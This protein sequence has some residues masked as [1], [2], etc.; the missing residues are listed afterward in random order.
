M[1]M[2]QKIGAVL[3]LSA[4]ALSV[5]LLSPAPS[6][7]AGDVQWRVTVGGGDR[8]EDRRYDQRQDRGRYDS[9]RDRD[10]YGHSRQRYVSAPRGYYKNVWHPPVYRTRYDSCGRSF[11]V[12]VSGGYY[13]RVWVSVGSGGGSYCR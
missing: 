9:R 6:A 8:H 4:A 12:R 7:S 3:G 5:S 1:K 11:R 10:G 2:P 13:S